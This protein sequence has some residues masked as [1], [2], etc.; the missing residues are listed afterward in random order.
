MMTAPTTGAA[1]AMTG[2]SRRLGFWGTEGS[3]ILRGGSGWGTMPNSQAIAWQRDCT[4]RAIG[5]IQEPDADWGD[6]S[7]ADHEEL[8]TD[9]N[10]GP[11]HHAV[12]AIRFCAPRA[13]IRFPDDRPVSGEP[14]LEPK[15]T[16][17]LP[18]LEMGLGHGLSTVENPNEV[19]EEFARL[20]LRVSPDESGPM[21][22]EALAGAELKHESVPRNPAD[23]AGCFQVGGIILFV[24]RE[25]RP[26]SRR[27]RGIEYLARN[28]RR[29]RGDRDGRGDR[30]RRG[31]RHRRNWFR[32]RNWF[33]RGERPAGLGARQVDLPRLAGEEIGRAH[34]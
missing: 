34:V 23:N 5:G 2:K 29:A 26:W 33:G 30:N 18:E 12:P 1:V 13:E 32:R 4:E 20:R 27:R 21:H 17:L 24:R 9:V 16:A 6:Q 25:E 19:V 31:D 11:A 7:S 8:L 22:G 14:V 10:S 3:V 15:R 28:D